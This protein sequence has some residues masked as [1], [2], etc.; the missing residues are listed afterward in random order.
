MEE[1]GEEAAS[2]LEL[3]SV[4]DWRRWPSE[5]DAIEEGRYRH[6]RARSGG[7]GAPVLKEERRRRSRGG[8]AAGPSV[9][10]E[11]RQRHDVGVQLG[12][13]A[14][15]FEGG[16]SVL[17]EQR[18]SRGVLGA[19]AARSTW[20]PGVWGGLLLNAEDNSVGTAHTNGGVALADGLECIL[21][22]E[23]VVVGGEDSDRAV[24]AGHPARVARYQSDCTRF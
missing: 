12:D 15:G 13:L 22:L 3:R 9:L 18:N 6:S 17:E 4:A 2:G 10:E 16:P 8:R 5:G 14:H 23:V 7:R 1:R 24:V 19:G 20:S 21:H 11:G